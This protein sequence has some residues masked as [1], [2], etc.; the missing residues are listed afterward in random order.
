MK[1]NRALGYGIVAV[2]TMVLISSCSKIASVLS[3]TLTFTTPAQ[4][5]TIPPVSDSAVLLTT[6]YPLPAVNGSFNYNLDSFIKANTG[7]VLGINNIASVRINNCTFNCS[8][9]IST[10]NFQDFQTVTFSFTSTSN[11]TPFTLTVNQ[12]D[13]FASSM[14]LTP[15]DTSTEMKSYLSGS[16]FNY[17]ISGQM[18]RGTS[19]SMQCN[20]T[21][22]FT[23]NVHG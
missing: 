20:V 10:A 22:T 11:T 13:V 17:G 18:R 23:I 9:A 19:D 2:S 15:T 5:F 7:G 14:V 16:S 3:K 4:S 21:F 12:P 1:L 8:N 6:F